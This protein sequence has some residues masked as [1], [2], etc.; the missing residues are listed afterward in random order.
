[1]ASVTWT[2]TA[3]LDKPIQNAIK[4]ATASSMFFRA[5]STAW[6][7]AEGAY[8][9]TLGDLCLD[10]YTN[11]EGILLAFV[12]PEANTVSKPELAVGVN[13]PRLRMV[14][15]DESDFAVGDI[16]AGHLYIFRQ[17]YVNGVFRWKLFATSYDRER[18]AEQ[19]EQ[20]SS[21]TEQVRDSAYVL[22]QVDNDLPERPD[23]PTTVL[24]ACWD[25]PS[26][27][28]EPTD[29]H[30]VLPTPTAPEIVPSGAWRAWDQRN[31][32]GIVVRLLDGAPNTNPPTLEAGIR[33]DGTTTYTMSDMDRDYFISGMTLGSSYDVE[34]RTTNF[35]GNGPYSTPQTVTITDGDM[36]DD[37]TGY[38]SFSDG[39][40]ILLSST[41][42]ADKISV[43]G[44]IMTVEYG[45][46]RV[47]QMMSDAYY[48]ADHFA[49]VTIDTP[50]TV[51]TNDR[52]FWIVC[53]AQEDGAGYGFRMT[54][55]YWQFGPT[56]NRTTDPSTIKFYWVD[57]VEFNGTPPSFPLT[58]RV[59]CQGT[60]ITAKINGTVVAQITDDTY[61][62]GDVWIIFDTRGASNDMVLSNFAA[63][64]L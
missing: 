47:F 64:D 45:S 5:D 28:M 24:W 50:G 2:T 40:W 15:T 54:E 21:L 12:A 17:S 48:P 16:A 51:T 1:M 35:V 20:I 36:V 13:S 32:G 34:L 43:S 4:A 56:E 37:F 19:E 26:E 31:G 59:E 18:I 38:T 61:A 9:V 58:F 62:D 52:G 57:N 14:D 44:G 7:E 6:D 10:D 46:S 27:V 60:T 23:E 11:R 63:G 29:F 42:K 41:D 53:R 25:D 55:T 39:P 22:R 3:D 8:I 49:E 30:M 33:V